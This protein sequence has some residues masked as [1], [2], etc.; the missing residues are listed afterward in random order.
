MVNYTTFYFFFPEKKILTKSLA[1]LHEANA[2]DARTGSRPD[3]LLTSFPSDLDPPSP[4]TFVLTGLVPGVLLLQGILAV[5][6]HSHL[7]SNGTACLRPSRPN[8][9]WHQPWHPLSLPFSASSL[10]T[11]LLILGTL[12]A[13][14]F[15]ATFLTW[16]A[17][18]IRA[19]ITI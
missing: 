12:H 3:I 15:I 16:N 4:R 1:N 8:K 18:S 9:P 10:A 2:A 7:F 17:N 13:F 5:L 19:G 14:L 6:L 11:I